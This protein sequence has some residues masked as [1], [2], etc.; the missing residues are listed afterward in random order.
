MRCSARR[1][2][3]RPARR[4]VKE[5]E[6]D[7]SGIRRCPVVGGIIPQ[8]FQP[9]AGCLLCRI[10]ADPLAER[11]RRSRT[12]RLQSRKPAAANNHDPTRLVVGKASAPFDTDPVVSS[13]RTAQWWPSWKVL[14]VALAR[15]LLIAFW[16]YVTA[17]VVLEG[18][19]T[20]A[21]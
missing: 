14:I 8:L 16:K 7:W 21:A 15:K 18:A 20:M 5:F 17:G 11:I 2:K 10:G 19:E 4:N 13:T 6:G 1:T 3:A 12:R 9:T